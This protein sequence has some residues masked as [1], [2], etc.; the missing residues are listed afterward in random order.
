[1]SGGG[2]GSGCPADG[3][4][5]FTNIFAQDTIA[6]SAYNALQMMVEKRFSHGL[7]LQ[8]AYTW[9]K[10]LDWASSFEESLNPYD[11]KASRALSVFNAA[12]RFVINY[13]WEIPTGKHKGLLGK[14]VDNWSISGITQFQS[15]F[16]IRLQTQDDTELINSLFFIG[17]GAP[18]LSTGEID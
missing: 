15:G 4:P 7:Q 14:V 17:T 12:Q 5:V 9:S 13:Y 11:F 1:M 2:V 3:T 10:S 16:P 18:Q 8:A 6:S